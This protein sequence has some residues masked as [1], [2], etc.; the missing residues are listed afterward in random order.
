[1]RIPSECYSAKIGWQVKVS[2]GRRWGEAAVSI[3]DRD[4]QRGPSQTMIRSS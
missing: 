2:V 4:I 1:M 3:N